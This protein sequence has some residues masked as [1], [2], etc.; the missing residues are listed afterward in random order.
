MTMLKRFASALSLILLLVPATTMAATT[1]QQS[2]NTSLIKLDQMTAGRLDLTVDIRYD[3]RPVVAGATNAAG[4]AKLRLTLR[5]DRPMEQGSRNGEGRFVVEAA[6]ISSARSG[7]SE[8]EVDLSGPIAIEWKYV[9]GMM[10]FRI[11]EM[12]TEVRQQFSTLF[13]DV[14]AYIGH[15]FSMDARQD[16]P[17]ISKVLDDAG[18][19]TGKSPFLLT[20]VEKRERTADGH[21][22]VRLRARINP[23]M[24]SVARWNEISKIKLTDPMR[25]Y[26]IRTINDRYAQMRKYMLPAQFVFM[27]D[28]TDQTVKR[29]EVGGRIAT[30]KKSCTYDLRLRRSV[31]RTQSV[32]SFTYL[33]G[34]NILPEATTPIE[35][36]A[37]A[38]DFQ[39]YM[40]A[41]IEKM[42]PPVTSTPA[43]F[44]TG[45][46]TLI[47]P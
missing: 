23:T 16:A 11:A 3:E 22:I 18:L 44:D 5:M 33:G 39:A 46:S 1:T 4:Q 21:D 14:S 10:Y 6:H 35:V 12:P 8:E 31:C 34:M 36:P 15:W 32:Q 7:L 45:T 26:R 42:Y 20:R 40:K 24:L 13:G 29:M 41:Q 28:T 25:A 19:P 2:L 9:N 30:P 37:D 43:V 27:I 47:A 17:S 38:S